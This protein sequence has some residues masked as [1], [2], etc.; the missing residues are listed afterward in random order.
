[1]ASDRPLKIFI[2]YSRKDASVAKA[3]RDSLL[4]LKYEVFIDRE[5]IEK[6]EEF[7]ARIQQLI[8]DSDVVL[9][10]LSPSS[11]VSTV[12][13]QEVELTNHLGKRLIPLVWRAFEGTIPAPLSKTNWISA[14]GSEPSQLANEACLAPV[15]AQL[16]RAINLGD[17]L[18]LR[19]HT[20]WVAR[21]AQWEMNGCK[22]GMVLRSDEITAG[23]SWVARRPQD[24]PDIPL[25]LI[26][27]INASILRETRDRRRTKI[28]QRSVG[29]L[30]LLAALVVALAGF[31]VSRLISGIGKRTS[32]TTAELSREAFDRSDYESAARFALAGLS[33]HSNILFGFN[34]DQSVA[35]LN[36]AVLSNRRLAVLAGA[37]PAKNRGRVQSLAL[38]TDG[39]YLLTASEDPVARLWDSKTGHLVREFAIYDPPSGEV[40]DSD[41]DDGMPASM[42]A[43]LPSIAIFS[44]DE[45]RV[46]TARGSTIHVFDTQSG[47]LI[48]G[49]QGEK[50]LSGAIW[51][52]DISPDGSAIL[53]GSLDNTARLWDARHGSL[54]RTLEGHTDYVRYATFSPDGSRILTVSNDETARVWETESGYVL[55]ELTG[56]HGRIF[57]GAFSNDGERAVTGND[58]GE[59]F[60]WDI[61][62]GEG[63]V[64]NAVGIWW[65]DLR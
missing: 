42:E 8:T 32:L 58:G 48:A 22:D 31:G 38:S 24:T 43:E 40:T 35:E 49:V 53:A 61:K 25:V 27:F 33:G 47:N 1:M 7:W 39:R 16:T 6:G 65:R 28:L 41:S 64:R 14:E 45:T 34:A 36:A 9:F 37:P 4:A 26:N 51:S 11:V 23:Q 60:I 12:C 17:I 2:S 3:L 63:A 10:V 44:K 62:S 59:V 5:N 57:H 50:G 18:W 56:H 52:I 15:V 30:V 19:E 54:I 20:N 55:K 29:T 13:A 21:A 46:V